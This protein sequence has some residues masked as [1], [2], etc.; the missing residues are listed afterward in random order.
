MTQQLRRGHSIAR[1]NRSTRCSPLLCYQI[2]GSLEL[3]YQY[4]SSS[5]TT[6]RISYYKCYHHCATCTRVA[7]IA[8]VCFKGRGHCKPTV[9]RRRESHPSK[10]NPRLHLDGQASGDDNHRELVARGQVHL[11]AKAVRVSQV[12][13]QVLSKGLSDLVWKGERGF[14]WCNDDVWKSPQ[15]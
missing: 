8:C 7:S 3:Q 11:E 6:L 10:V 12:S 9:S 4:S 15:F 13:I 5:E 14:V 2:G 1:S